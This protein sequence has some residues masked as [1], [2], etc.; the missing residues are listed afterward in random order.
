[1]KI[2]S[3]EVINYKI[4]L[5]EQEIKFLKSIIGRLCFNRLKELNCPY[6]DET[7][8]FVNKLYDILPGKYS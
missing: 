8:I 2:E 3:S 1:M 5:D 6:L 7:Q 4:H